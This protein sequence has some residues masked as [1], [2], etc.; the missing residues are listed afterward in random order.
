MVFELF[1][2]SELTFQALKIKLASRYSTWINIKLLLDLWQTTEH[3]SI[4]YV[5]SQY[6]KFL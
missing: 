1:L 3:E 2:V 4:R 6:Y 5:L